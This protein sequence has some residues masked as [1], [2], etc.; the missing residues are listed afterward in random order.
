M[1][2]RYTEISFFDINITITPHTASESKYIARPVSISEFA[3]EQPCTLQKCLE[4]GEY[5]VERVSGRRPWDF[6]EG[7]EV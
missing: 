1:G 5:L 3:G 6:I 7:P 2:T 4:T